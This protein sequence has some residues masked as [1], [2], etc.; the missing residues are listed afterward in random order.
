MSAS[1]LTIRDATLDDAAALVAIYRPYVEDTAISFELEVPSVCAFAERIAK[2]Q[3]KWAWL[4]AERAGQLAGYA[5]GTEHRARE[6]YAYSVETS[7]YVHRDHHRA[8]IAR[9]LYVALLE[10]LEALG[11]A[12]AYA[13]TTLPNEASVGLHRHLG[14]EPIGVFPRVGYKFG[15]WHDVAWL[16]RPIA[17]PGSRP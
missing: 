9:A 14:F 4:V 1:G 16:H 13:G 3:S 8:G 7:A 6:A 12:N 10:R 15:Q 17:M 2:A 11:F 5:Y